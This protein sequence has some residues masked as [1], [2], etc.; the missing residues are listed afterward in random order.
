LRG[1]LTQQ[2]LQRAIWDQLHHQIGDAILLAKVEDLDDIRV[3]E[4]CSRP[5]LAQEARLEGGVRRLAGVQDFESGWTVQVDVDSAID[6]AHPANAETLF[7]T[8]VSNLLA[9]QTGHLIPP[10]PGSVVCVFTR[11]GRA[12]TR[13]AKSDL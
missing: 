3:R 8:V 1:S 5:S 12:I 13:R 6:L 4:R 10:P 9:N 11:G 7:D 2:S